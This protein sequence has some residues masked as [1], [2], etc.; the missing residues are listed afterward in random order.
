MKN[1]IAVDMGSSNTYIYRSGMGI[2][3]EEPSAVA[4]SRT[5]G[6]IKALGENAK[7]L[8]GMATGD[9]EVTFPVFEGYVDNF[10]LAT[11][12][13]SGYLQKVK[14]YHDDI[15]ASVPCGTDSEKLRY[16]EKFFRNQGAYNVSLVESPLLTAYGMGIMTDSNAPRFVINIGGGTTNIA[17]VTPEGVITGVSINVGGQNV[18]SMLV[19]HIETA[20][21]LKIGIITAEKLKIRLGSMWENDELRHVVNGRDVITGRPK[22]LSVEAKDIY[23]PLC[24]FYNIIIS[25]AEK[26]MAKLPPEALG[27]INRT[28]IFIAGGMSKIAG[29]KEYFEEK[30]GVKAVISDEGEYANILG[31]GT[32]CANKSLLNK[33]KMN[34]Y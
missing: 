14:F 10:P 30:L 9:M 31:A 26:I 5:Q 4:L 20:F 24:S 22:P 6:K 16:L 18:D 32:L 21:R 29:L 1:A 28:G 23:A 12:M 25:V 17:A 7:K 13:L 15:I 11:Q 2:V 33:L 19:N 3:L 8:Y 34:K 27:E